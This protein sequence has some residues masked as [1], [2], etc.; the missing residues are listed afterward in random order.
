MKKLWLP[1][2]AMA[3]LAMASTFA[4]ASSIAVS[5]TNGFTD[6]TPI[7]SLNGEVAGPITQW[8]AAYTETVGTS[9]DFL[10]YGT[11]DLAFY[12][13]VENIGPGEISD[14]ND[15]NFGTSETTVGD[16][17]GDISFAQDALGTVNILLT[18]G[19][20]N[21]QTESF[22]IYTNSTTWVPGNLT[23]ADGGSSMDSGYGT[24]PIPITPEP[25]S[26]LLLGTGLVGLAFIAFRKAKPARPVLH[27]N[28]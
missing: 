3:T 20:T 2:L 16:I 1:L 5:D 18:N 22:V 21:G 7:I 9:T 4:H 12:I 28:M 24:T 13:T 26:L 27:L 19:L 25:S 17:T 6:L 8:I 10:S 11:G 14:V 15:Y 23:F